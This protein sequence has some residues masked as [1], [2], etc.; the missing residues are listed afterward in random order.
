MFGCPAARRAAAACGE[1]LGFPQLS[2]GFGEPG[3][4]HEQRREQG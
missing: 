4:A 2:D 1:A 3:E